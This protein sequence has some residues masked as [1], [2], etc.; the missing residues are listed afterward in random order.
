MHFLRLATV[1]LLLFVAPPVAAQTFPCDLENWDGTPDSGFGAGP[2]EIRAFATTL[3]VIPQECMSGGVSWVNGVIVNATRTGVSPTM[4]IELVEIRVNPVNDPP[5]LN[6][7][8]TGPGR[9]IPNVAVFPTSTRQIF[10]VE[11]KTFV[12]D[13]DDN[14]TVDEYVAGVVYI[15]GDSTPDQFVSTSRTGPIVPCFTG[16]EGQPID[17]PCSNGDPLL[18]GM[19]LGMQ[20]AAGFARIEDIGGTSVSV[21]TNNPQID[22]LRNLDILIDAA[23]DELSIMDG[24]GG[25]TICT[26]L[27]VP[28]G[29]LSVCPLTAAQAERWRNAQAFIEWIS[30]SAYGEER[31]IPADHF[32]SADGFES[33]DTSRWSSTVP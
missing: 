10:P 16:L 24:P 29:A 6:V 18:H 20:T 3:Q 32:I 2:G 23:L 22:P 25:P 1:F 21:R 33:G 5:S 27:N 8:S 17:E 19:G 4:P 14:G 28:A 12:F 30:T 31:I 26:F 9:N 15:D 7:V 11:P 13:A